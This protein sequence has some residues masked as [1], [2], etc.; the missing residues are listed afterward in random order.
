MSM[1]IGILPFFGWMPHTLHLTFLAHALREL[2]HRVETLTCDARLDSCYNIEVRGAER[3]RRSCR[4][5]RLSN[6]VVAR[7]ADARAVFSR[8]GSREARD[9]APPGRE[10]IASSLRTLHR[11][12]DDAELGD[13]MRTDQARRLARASEDVHA[14]VSRW[15]GERALDFVFLFNGR[16]DISRAAIGALRE[17]GIPFASVERALTGRGML[18]LPGEDCLGLETLHPLV[19]GARDTFLTPAQAAGAGAFL[20]DRVMGRTKTE[21]RNYQEGAVDADW[22]VASPERRV[23]ILP[24]SRNEVLGTT[25]YAMVWGDP[26]EGYDAVLAAYGVDPGSVVVRGHPNWAQLIGVVPGDRIDRHYRDW[27]TARGY[28][29]IPAAQKHRTPDL[30]RPA[31]AVLVSHSSA[32]FETVIL[33][34]PLIAIGGAHY[35][36]AGF[37]HDASSPEALAG[38]AARLP[39]GS[40]PP[41]MRRAHQR[42]LLRY[43]HVTTRR[44]PLF[45]DSVVPVSAGYCDLH[46]PPARSLERLGTLLETGALTLEPQEEGTGPQAE[47]AVIDCIAQGRDWPVPGAGDAPEGQGAPPWPRFWGRPVLDRLLRSG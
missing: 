23:L 15:A 44:L 11:I 47:D 31:D 10:W 25:G 37:A 32:A 45:P 27:A 14:S 20:R 6:A 22:P 24:S 13:L 9:D 21:W 39:L 46:R 16:V 1:R 29:Y 19:A 8:Y 38:L 26:T 2:G 42:R 3:R 18:V 43:I 36:T 12:E 28:H 5:C 33:G 34:R 7:Q 41:G 35:S 4:V 40:D 30:I 17:K